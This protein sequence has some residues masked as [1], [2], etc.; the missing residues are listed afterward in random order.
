MDSS[1]LNEW[2]QVIGIF[3]VVASLVFVGIQVQQTEDI[4]IS[5]AQLATGE[6]TREY[7][8]VLIDNAEIWHAGCLGEELSEID[9]MRFA[10]L[11]TVYTST[12]FSAWKRLH[13]SDV[14]DSNP[15]Y[16]IDSYAANHYRFPA[17][18]RMRTERRA[19]DE[20]GRRF[21]DPD[22]PLFGRLVSSRITE[23][24]E[25]EPIPLVDVRFC[26]RL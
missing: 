23:L 11:Y 13:N 24:R 2:V 3:A 9:D 5:E 21:S 6:R 17:I 8:A 20:N 26:G 4:A 10:K 19:W 22:L 25:I 16:I 12:M 18:N 7:L 15:D 1:K 14:R